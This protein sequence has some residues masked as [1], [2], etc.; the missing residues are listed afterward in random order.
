MKLNRAE[1][2]NINNNIQATER[3]EL[4]Q[5]KKELLKSIDNIDAISSVYFNRNYYNSIINDI[6]KKYS[7][8]H[9]VDV[10]KEIY[11]SHEINCT[12][13]E[14]LN[15]IVIR[16]GLISNPDKN[17]RWFFKIESSNDGFYKTYLIKQLFDDWETFDEFANNI[18]S[19]L[20]ELY[21]RIY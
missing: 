21:K 14:N 7:L 6:G 20:T 8:W 4:I 10:K 3:K 19:N 1:L 2:I 9:G 5:K 13:N 11:F 15:L 16:F 18:D 12:D 17:R